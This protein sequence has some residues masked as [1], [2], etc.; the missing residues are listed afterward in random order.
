MNLD[1]GCSGQSVVGII[2]PEGIHV[3]INRNTNYVGVSGTC[4]LLV[5]T[6]YY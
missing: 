6:S 3:S 2:L 5:M 1:N 4:I